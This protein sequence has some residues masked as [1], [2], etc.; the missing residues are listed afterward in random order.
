VI[1]NPPYGVRLSRGEDFEVSLA[2]ALRNLRGH[3]VSA[4]CHDPKLAA[5]MRAK[6]AQEHALWNGDLE[7]RLFSWDL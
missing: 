1:T 3:R 7:C 6:P 4:I 5:A 2:K